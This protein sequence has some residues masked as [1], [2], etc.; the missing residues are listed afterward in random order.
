[1][2]NDFG[3]SV[4]VFCYCVVFESTNFVFMVLCWL[5]CNVSREHLADTVHPG[6]CVVVCVC[7]CTRALM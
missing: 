1:M 7:V 3:C 5:D 2:S 4:S 6:G